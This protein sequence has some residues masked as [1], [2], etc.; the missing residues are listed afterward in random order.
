MSRRRRQVAVLTALWLAGIC[1]AGYCATGVTAAFSAR[2]LGSRIGGIFPPSFQGVTI[3]TVGMTVGVVVV[4]AAM[5]VSL[6]SLLF[7]LR[8]VPTQE[9]NWCR[10]VGVVGSLLARGYPEVAVLFILQLIFGTQIQTVLVC[11]AVYTG[12]VLGRLLDITVTEDQK[13]PYFRAR[14]AGA[15][16]LVAFTAVLMASIETLLI[17]ACLLRIDSVLRKIVVLGVASAGGLGLTFLE[18]YALGDFAVVGGVCLM[19]FCCHAGLELVA[20]MAGVNQ[21]ASRR[22]RSAMRGAVRRSVLVGLQTLGFGGWVL[23]LG[24][25]LVTPRLIPLYG[26]EDLHARYIARRLVVAAAETLF[27]ALAAAALGVTLGF[28]VGLAASVSL[29]RRRWVPHGVRMLLAAA[30]AIPDILLVMLAISA[31]GLGWSSGAVVLAVLS[32]ITTAKLFADEVDSVGM[33]SYRALRLAGASFLQGIL[34]GLLPRIGRQLVS[35]GLWQIEHNVR[36]AVLIGSVGAGGLG[37]FLV[38]A[39]NAGSMPGLLAG[40]FVACALVGCIELLG[41]RW[42][43]ERVSWFGLSGEFE[44]GRDNQDDRAP[45]A[46]R[47]EGPPV[48]GSGRL[49]I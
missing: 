29:S 41:G 33:G 10:R 43:G 24:S 2:F 48:V 23:C 19:L 5:G 14:Q 40:G 11:V 30:R 13:A 47:E 38:E 3:A 22:P 28:L 7:L 39:R 17:R 35:I 46:N 27:S 21:S 49:S 16:H 20:V 25:L 1:L 32:T 34:G 18:S 42:D 12:G 4:A 44:A 26:G 9:S 36:N 15:P 6:G 45:A 8:S 37:Y 31:V